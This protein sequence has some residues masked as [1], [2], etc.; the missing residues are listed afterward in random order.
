MA[1]GNHLHRWTPQASSSTARHVR[2]ARMRAFGCQGGWSSLWTAH[3]HL[4]PA[5]ALALE[6]SVHIDAVL[7]D[8]KSAE[9]TGRFV[10]GKRSNSWR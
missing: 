5:R 10:P 2:L 6:R 4:E 3:A 9:P 8:R 7:F 1:N